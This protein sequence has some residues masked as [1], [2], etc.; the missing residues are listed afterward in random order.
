MAKVVGMCGQVG[1]D[2]WL[3]WWGWVAK[4]VMMDG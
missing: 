3:S 4:L 2:R 1:D